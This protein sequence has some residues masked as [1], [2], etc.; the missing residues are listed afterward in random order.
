METPPWAGP[1]R[2]A[3]SAWMAASAAGERALRTRAG[4]VAPHNA[5]RTGGHRG[6][7]T[8]RTAAGPDSPAACL[9]EH[10]AD[11]AAL[12]TPPA[13]TCQGMLA[14]P[15]GAAEREPP[16]PCPACS[17]AAPGAGSTR[18]GHAQGRL[19]AAGARLVGVAAAVAAPGAERHTLLGC[20]GEALLAGALP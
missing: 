4:R 9:V 8:R 5:G 12:Q 16:P 13:G 11:T 14:A 17:A 18:G 3:L 7:D 6:P 20:P 10:K 2:L 19:P 15:L 1:R